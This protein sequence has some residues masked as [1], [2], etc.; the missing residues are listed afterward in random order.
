[1]YGGTKHDGRRVVFPV[2][3]VLVLPQKPDTADE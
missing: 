2:V 3:A 1:M